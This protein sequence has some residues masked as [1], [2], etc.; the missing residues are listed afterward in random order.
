MTKP[1]LLFFF[2]AF[3]A[4]TSAAPGYAIDVIRGEGAVNGVKLAYQYHIDQPLNSD[5]PVT[6]TLETS[7]NFWEYGERDEY[8]SNL[9]LALSPILRIPVGKIHG[10]PIE[11]EF[12]IGVSLLDDTR[13]AGKDV[14]THYQFEDRIGVST[15]FGNQQQYRL[16]LRYLHYS[17]A[18]FKKP[19]PGLDFISL[20][21]SQR[22]D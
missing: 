13:F 12:G 18:G 21:F 15:V 16:A 9:V 22:W 3:S 5:W 11:A 7:A 2:L 1:T 20:S 6:L 17:N 10:F 8:D 19:N 14:S 4:A